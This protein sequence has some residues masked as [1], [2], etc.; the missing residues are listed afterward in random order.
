MRTA[1]DQELST[2]VHGYELTS[3]AYFV[4]AASGG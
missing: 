2:E 3:V 1:F 4:C